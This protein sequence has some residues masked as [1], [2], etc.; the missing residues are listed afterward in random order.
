MENKINIL[1]VSCSVLISL[2]GLFFVLKIWLVWNKVDKTVLKAR[3]FLDSNFLTK[4]WILVFMAGAFITIRRVVQL[5][6]LLESPLI[7]TPV[8]IIN[9]L[10]GLAVIILLV[11]LAYYW[12]RLVYSTIK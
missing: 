12:Y 8:K 5:L 10:I 4:N 9:D 7:S 1:I 2:I 3:V 6:E 11:L